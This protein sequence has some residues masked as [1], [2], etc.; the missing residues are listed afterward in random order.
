VKKTFV[1][2]L[3]AASLTSAAVAADQKPTSVA[4]PDVVAPGHIYVH[5]FVNVKEIQGPWGYKKIFVSDAVNNVVNIYNS[6]GKQ[7]A[8]LAGF[9]EPQ[10]LATDSNGKL[11]VADTVDSRIQIYAP[12]YNKTPKTLSDPGQYPAGV[13]VTIVGKTTYVAVT[14]I[15]DVNG[16]P[17]SVTIFK[18]GKAEP[19]ILSSAFSRVYFDAF[20]AD[21]NLYIDGSDANG[22]VVI[23]EIAK[24]T[25]TGKTIAVLTTGNTILFPGG[26]GVTIKGKIAIDDQDAA[27]VYSYNP[28]K[29]GSLGSPIKTTP[30]TGSSDAVTFAFTATNTSLWTADAGNEDS[31]EFAYPKG[32]SA[33]HS[34]SVSGGQPIGVAMV[35]TQVP[36]K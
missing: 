9:I 31:N 11:Y 22:N 18:N 33:L 25:T 28:P 36:G 26:V 12:P 17:G 30:L 32:G 2:V 4:R 20:D 23:G 16:G 13:S 21:G 7:L 27:T 10:G 29:K 24:A 19:T 8:Q 5:P 35:P 34:I 6:S 3:L 1:A 14:N 15:I